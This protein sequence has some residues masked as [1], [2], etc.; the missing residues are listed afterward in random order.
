LRQA[1]ESG[2][3][4]EV[5][6]FIVRFGRAGK[7]VNAFEYRGY[8]IDWKQIDTVRDDFARRGLELSAVD[9]SWL[10]RQY[11]DEREDAMTLNSIKN[12]VTKFDLLDGTA[13]EHLLG[14]L[15]EKMGY[16][17]QMTG[18]TGDQG[19]D[20][21][22]TRAPERIVIQAKCYKNQSVGN[23]AVQEAAAA[24]SMYDGNKAMVITTSDF[25]KEARELAR[26]TDVELISRKELQELLLKYLSETWG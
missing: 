2:F 8:R 20:L 13:F 25:T 22:A 4:E 16:A 9:F 5:K 12:P 1:R 24:R 19:G 15:Y 18:K 6:T 11:I 23:A 21:V 3:E 14:R 10:L 17:V 26:A 7:G